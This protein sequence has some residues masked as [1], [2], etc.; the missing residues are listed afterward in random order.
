MKRTLLI[1]LCLVTL[2]LLGP[3]T[4]LRADEG[5]WT[6]DNLPLDQLRE[7]YG[8]VPTPEW[9]DHLRLSSVRVGGSSGSFVSSDGL[10]MTNM[11]VALGY[12]QSLSG[13]DADYVTNGFYAPTRQAELTAPNLEVTVLISMEQ[14]T[15]RVQVAAQGLLEADALRARQA[16]IASIEKES[17][18]ATGL[19]SSVVSLYN[20]GE[21]WLY[22]QRRYT[23]V[24]LVF[25]PE[26]QAAFFGGDTDNF[27]YPRYCL[28][29]AFFRIY[30]DGA[31]IETP[32]YLTIKPE[33]PDPGDL[34][35]VSGHPGSTD[36]LFTYDQ[37]EYQRDVRYPV[38]LDYFE[39]YRGLVREYAAGGDERARRVQRQ[40]LGIENTLKA[41]SGEYRGLT[42]V[43]LMRRLEEA[44]ADFRDRIAGSRR[45]D[46]YTAA[47]EAIARATG[48]AADSFA[49]RV[50]RGF[51]GSGLTTTAGII[52]R[53]V[54]EV[55]KPDADRL[56]GYHDSE[57][58]GLRFQILS[59][60][61]VYPD[62]E[63]HVVTGFLEKSREVLG[64]NDPWVASVLD[65][66]TP[67]AVASRLLEQTRLTDVEF[68]RSLIE[69][70]RSAV[71]SSDDP[72]IVAAREL[73]PQRRRDQQ[74]Y[75]D[76]VESVLTDA[77]ETLA[78][79]RFDLFG[80]TIYPDATG[81]LRISFGTVSGYPMNGARAPHETTLYGLFDRAIGFG[82]AGD[83]ALPQ[84]YWDRRDD[85]DLST[86]ANFVTTADIIG[87]NSGSPVVN[88]DGALVGLIFDGNIESLVG[89]YAYEAERARSVAVH[90]GYILEALDVLYDAGPLAEELTGNR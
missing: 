53:Y 79:A 8:F 32:N 6:Y 35:F 57:L 66:E 90:P 30:D 68:R 39:T 85:L 11:H 61:P 86:P 36:R 44:D 78:T 10:L 77:G 65:G 73:D 82:N 67:A 27:T 7:R 19:L 1:A 37:L 26:N 60:A 54:T 21:Y 56:P 70:G 18:D 76:E 13:P 24:R 71:A 88:G 84:R 59:S 83:H 17:L 34:V 69:G 45:P 22:R 72:L 40:L 87:G 74:W 28:D 2:V 89:R 33:G 43:E 62:L 4:S 75:R 81:T 9:L 38:Y 80:R 31:P 25:A 3:A 64:A 52:V 51:V 63:A 15:G 14:V 29:V 58:E 42:D 41:M 16:E 55:E 46:D 5:M 48:H 47:F 50:Y 20:G 49:Q 23:D 12:V